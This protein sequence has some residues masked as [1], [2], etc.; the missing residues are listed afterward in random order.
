MLMNPSCN[1]LSLRQATRRVTQLCDQA[2]APL[3]LRANQLSMLR[4]I[5][6]L[7]LINA[8][9]SSDVG[10]KNAIGPFPFIRRWITVGRQSGEPRSSGG[11][12]LR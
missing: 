2:L 11:A 9:I 12:R 7:G 3:D 1:R 6:R 4:E 10:R 5:D 8:G